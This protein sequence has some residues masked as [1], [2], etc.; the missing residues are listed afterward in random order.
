[1]GFNLITVG[2]DKNKL[3]LLKKDIAKKNQKNCFAFDFM[4]KNNYKKFL[5]IIKKQKKIN[6][7]IHCIGGGFGLHNPVISQEDLNFLFNIN[8]STA[9]GINKAILGGKKYNKNLKIIH[10]GSVASIENTASVGYSMVKASLV[11]YT[12]TLSKSLIKKNIFIHCIL[13]GAFEYES[14]S[15]E[16]LKLRN[17]KIYND[18]IKKKLPR[19]VIAKGENFLGLFDFILSN[20]S[21]SLAGSSIVADFSETNSF[22]I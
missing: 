10:I 13:L 19:K 4:V 8:V 16:R 17:K 1:M 6:A 22:R 14:N 9:V 20:D 11:A 18:F 2:K 15:F 12:K 5:R 21:N 3:K 7:V